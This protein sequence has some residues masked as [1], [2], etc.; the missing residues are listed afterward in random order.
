[1]SFYKIYLVQ[2]LQYFSWKASEKAATLRNCACLPKMCKFR[3]LSTGNEKKNY[4]I[5]KKS[6]PPKNLLA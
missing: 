4:I 5:N 3:K 6:E 2:L 1:M